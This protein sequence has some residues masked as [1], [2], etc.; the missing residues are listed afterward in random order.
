MSFLDDIFRSLKRAGDAMSCA[1]FMTGK[2]PASVGAVTCR[3]C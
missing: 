3:D 1:S 2:R